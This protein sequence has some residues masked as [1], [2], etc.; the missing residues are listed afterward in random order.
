LGRECESGKYSQNSHSLSRRNHFLPLGAFHQ[1]RR[2]FTILHYSNIDKM[3][4][5]LAI[6]LLLNF[7]ALALG[8][9]F[10]SKGVSS[11]WYINL[12]KAPWTPPGWVFGAAWTTIMICFSFYMAK[13]W[14]VSIDNKPLIL[15]YTA[16]WILNVGWN[17]TFFY[18]NNVLLALFL[19][20]ALTLLIGFILLYY[21]QSLKLT[22][23]LIAPYFIWLLIAT[24]LNGYIFFKIK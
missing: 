4:Y 23:L 8:G 15:L 16:Q 17:P 6:F 21:W 13:A 20:G 10:T 5:R 14:S 22:S 12:S 24:S 19:I 1:L 9:I 3:I 18:Y 7:G 2:K 11:D